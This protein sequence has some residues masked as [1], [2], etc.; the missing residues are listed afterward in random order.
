M[1][2]QRF[3]EKLSRSI[4]SFNSVLS[5]WLGII[6]SNSSLLIQQ[7]ASVHWNFP[8][9]SELRIQPYIRSNPLTQKMY[10]KCWDQPRPKSE[11]P[12]IAH[13]MSLS[14][15]SFNETTIWHGIKQH[16]TLVGG[17]TGLADQQKHFDNKSKN[18][19][20]SWMAR[21]FLNFSTD[22]HARVKANTTCVHEGIKPSVPHVSLM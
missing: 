2:S 22:I 9:Q 8:I 19:I 17:Q 11:H 16:T 4:I 5:R 1:D 14:I 21:N 3:S 10:L 12:M 15:S 7:Q 6:I 13:Q 20:W 18:Q